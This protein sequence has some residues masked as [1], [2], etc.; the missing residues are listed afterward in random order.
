MRVC[1]CVFYFKTNTVR[2][3]TITSV[4]RIKR[5]WK[6][7]QIVFN[8]KISMINITIL[9]LINRKTDKIAFNFLII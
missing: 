1:W 3:K 2:L 8:R 6:Q 7:M 5:Q 4:K 9:L